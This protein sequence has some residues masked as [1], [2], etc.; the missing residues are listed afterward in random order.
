MIPAIGITGVVHYCGGEIASI[1]INGLESTNKCSCGSEEM[2]SNCCDDKH[3][4][5]Q[6][7]DEQ[8]KTPS[9]LFNLEASFDFLAAATPLLS[10]IYNSGLIQ[11]ENDYSHPPPDNVRPSLY[12]LHQVFRI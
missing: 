1:N 12:I 9:V 7:E 5:F 8:Y 6:L 3:F 4:S 11:K 2:E 10:F